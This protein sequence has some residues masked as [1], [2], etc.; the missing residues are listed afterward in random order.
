[1]KIFLV[2]LVPRETCP[3]DDLLVLLVPAVVPRLVVFEVVACFD[4]PV[5]EDCRLVL[6]PVD[7]RE[8]V[9]PVDRCVVVVPV[10][11]RVVVVAADCCLP[12]VPEPLLADVRVEAV[13]A[14]CLL[15][16]IL[17]ALLPD[18]RV[19]LSEYLRL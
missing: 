7:C 10:D 5:P 2:V 1:M 13:P 12:L 8:V 19:F 4:L 16:L 6:V 18:D 3:D 11:F 14:D 9:V 17:E 15:A